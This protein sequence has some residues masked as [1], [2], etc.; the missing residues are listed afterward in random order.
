MLKVLFLVCSR[1]VSL[2]TP[3][4]KLKSLA[5]AAHS[6]TALPAHADEQAVLGHVT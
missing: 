5:L 4:L 3:T 2:A 6:L 1:L